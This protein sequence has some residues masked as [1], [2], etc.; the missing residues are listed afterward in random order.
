MAGVFLFREER[1]GELVEGIEGGGVPLGKDVDGASA[2]PK[3]DPD[4]LSA[5]KL[6]EYDDDASTS[7]ACCRF[8]IIF[9]TQL[10]CS[11]QDPGLFSNIK[12][13]TY[14]KDNEEDPYITMKEVGRV[15]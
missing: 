8:Q 1:A 13:L 12:G 14:D 2:P 3:K 4:D 7:S 15:I 11:N 5:Y 6:D 9:F 10:T